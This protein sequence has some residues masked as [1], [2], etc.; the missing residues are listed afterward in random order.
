MGIYKTRTII[1]PSSASCASLF[2]MFFTE[3]KAKQSKS[4][5]RAHNHHSKVV[6]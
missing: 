2:Y 3:K 6:L 1:L 5:V 4:E